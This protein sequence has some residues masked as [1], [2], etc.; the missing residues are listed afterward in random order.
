MADIPIPDPL[1]M[2]LPPEVDGRSPTPSSLSIS[3][4]A[5]CF[6]KMC[7]ELGILWEILCESKCL[8]LKIE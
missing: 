1:S 2:A 4:N 6:W 7:F 5:F 8:P 3:E